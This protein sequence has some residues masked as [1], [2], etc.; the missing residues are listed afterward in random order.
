MAQYSRPHAYIPAASA[1]TDTS[2]DELIRPGLR[3]A[4]PLPSDED[5][6]EAQFQG[7]LATL[8]QRQGAS[9]RL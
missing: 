1:L 6:T 8:A 2:I 4:F 5:G 3:L 7:L 9:E